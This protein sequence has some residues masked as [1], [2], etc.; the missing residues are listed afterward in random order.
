M[1]CIQLAGDQFIFR[2]LHYVPGVNIDAY[3]N[4]DL[5]D[6]KVTL[7]DLAAKPII[8]DFRGEGH[9]L[10]SAMPLLNYLNHSGVKFEVKFSTDIDLSKIHYPAS[11]DLTFMAN[12]CNWFRQVG[13]STLDCKTKFLCL[14]RR[15]SLSRA[16]L[17]AGLLA[18]HKS[19]T[20]SFGASGDHVIPYQNL[21]GKKRKLPILID[22]IVGH[23][24]SHKHNVSSPVFHTSLFNII[25]ESSSQDDPN[26]WRSIFITE[27]TF[28][29]FGL[30][31]IPIWFAVPGL[32]NSV[33]SLGFDLFDD[34]VDHSYD[35]I[36]DEST[37]L[38]KLLEITDYLDR[39][40]TL[41]Q[42]NQQRDLIKNRLHANRKLLVRLIKGQQ[43]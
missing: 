38:N 23:E 25:V 29:C 17:A 36:T 6:S 2:A 41:E 40:Y 37:R 32:V 18:Q 43:Q 24:S 30:L 20:L 22:G 39:T 9:D 34:I 26:T 1:N 31:Q 10:K 35:A 16:R 13:A 42:C 33:R 12:H 3:F 28:K 4:R 27:K 14:M 8:V 15:P 21:F 7:N 5:L 11:K 19:I